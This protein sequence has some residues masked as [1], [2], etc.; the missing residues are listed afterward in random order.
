M[1]RAFVKERDGEEAPDSLPQRPVSPH[2]NYMTP[3]GLAELQAK[4][5]ELLREKARLSGE[6]S[7]DAVQRLRSVEREL[8][9]YEGRVASAIVAD[10]ATQPR[11]RV[12]FGATVE[13]EDETGAVSRYTI[14]GED[15]ADAARGRIS[16]VSPLARALLGAEV[17]ES[18]TWRRPAGDKELIVRAITA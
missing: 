1:S 16:W 9:Y 2:P 15:E 18:V 17:G 8:R 4:V 6:D 11:D 14:V 5:A 12:H 7:M 10:P 13:V 3:A